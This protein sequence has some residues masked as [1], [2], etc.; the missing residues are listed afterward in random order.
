MA[1]LALR[2]HASRGITTRSSLYW[3][4]GTRERPPAPQSFDFTKNKLRKGLVLLHTCSPL[5]SAFKPNAI[6]PFFCLFPFL[7]PLQRWFYPLLRLLSFSFFYLL[8][9]LL[10]MAL[11]PSNDVIT[12]RA[13]SR[14]EKKKN[15]LSLLDPGLTVRVLSWSR[16]TNGAYYCFVTYERTSID[17]CLV[18][19]GWVPR[20]FVP[21]SALNA[22][23]K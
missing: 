12:I 6:V 13:F 3:L 23:T 4:D 21:S 22:T 16:D 19:N 18:E 17:F 1:R 2:E 10:Q 15:F 7:D 11:W 5:C 14:R 9:P 8:S 20:Y